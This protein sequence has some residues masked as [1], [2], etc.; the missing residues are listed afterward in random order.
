MEI[1]KMHLCIAKKKNKWEWGIVTFIIH[2]KWVLA[3]TVPQWGEMSYEGA[4]LFSYTQICIYLS[5]HY[6]QK[7][8][9]SA[10]SFYETES[11]IWA[12]FG[13]L[14]KGQIKL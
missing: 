8:H 1:A 3:A 4:F 5:I 2:C 6:F 10:G 7:N 11:E 12:G 13:H 9:P 14:G